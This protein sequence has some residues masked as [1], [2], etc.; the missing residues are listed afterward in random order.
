MGLSAC[1]GTT[2]PS[3]APPTLVRTA[4]ITPS[5]TATLTPTS[6]STATPTS[7]PTPTPTPTLW[8][9]DET[10][11]PDGFAP[12]TLDNAAAVSALAE[13]K[14]L[15]VEDLEWVPGTL[16]LAVASPGSIELYELASRTLYRRLYPQAGEIV[17]IVFSPDRS[18][19]VSGSRRVVEDGS[20][21]SN[22]EVWTGPDLKPLGILTGIS[23]GL[24]RLAFTPDSRTFINSFT[25]P[26]PD[27]LG[28]LEFWRVPGWTIASRLSTGTVLEIAVSAD[29]TRLATSPD[30]YNLLIWET[31]TGKLL[32]EIPTSFTGAVSSLAFSPDRKTLASGHYDGT[33]RLWDVNSGTLI[34]E[35]IS[36]EII[37]TLEFSPDSTLLATGSG[38]EKSALRLWSVNTGELMRDLTG[39]STPITSLLFASDAR[40]LVSGSYDG[41]VRIWGIWP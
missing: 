18:W 6:T 13:W 20:Y 1:Q 33:I 26:E 27:Q 28:K 5:P 9:L 23:S 38:G 3:P 24:V 22:L 11:L 30:L 32:F 12:I 40:F 36:D 19:L 25:E 15:P 21:A 34:L 10:P 39:H 37:N 16:E 31:T 35:I 7:T 17:D 4:T 14:G 29:G 8:V 2:E 41:T